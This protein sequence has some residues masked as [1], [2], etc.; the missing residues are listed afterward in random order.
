MDELQVL[1]VVGKKQ[2]RMDGMPQDYISPLS[3]RSH[4]RIIGPL[5]VEWLVSCP[6]THLVEIELMDGSLFSN[7]KSVVLLVSL[8]F[9]RMRHI[10]ILPHLGGTVHQQS[11]IGS[12]QNNLGLHLTSQDYEP[13]VPLLPLLP[14]LAQIPHLVPEHEKQ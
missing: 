14:P 13:Q 2:V 6:S 3:Y 10:Q 7:H 1:R 8:L 11:H 4:L 12:G 9:S 5:F